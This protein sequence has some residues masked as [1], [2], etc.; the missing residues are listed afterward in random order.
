MEF[1]KG[2]LAK[3]SRSPVDVFRIDGCLHAAHSPSSSPPRLAAIGAN[4]DVDNV[5]AAP[6]SSSTFR[7]LGLACLYG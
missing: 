7:G 4:A 6:R 1:D 3:L 5:N 2:E